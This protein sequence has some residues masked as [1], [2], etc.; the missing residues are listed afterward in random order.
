[1]NI[2]IKSNLHFESNFES[3]NLDLVIKVSENEYNLFLRPDTYTCGDMQWF[4]FKV[5]NSLKQKVK[6]NI[7]N[8]KKAKTVYERVNSL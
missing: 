5:K 4:N 6:F 8:N 1:M 3:G 2:N 7:C